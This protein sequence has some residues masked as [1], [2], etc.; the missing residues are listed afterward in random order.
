[1]NHKPI[2]QQLELSIKQQ[3]FIKDSKINNTVNMV[4]ANDRIAMQ[5]VNAHN[6]SEFNP[7]VINQVCNRNEFKHNFTQQ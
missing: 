4:L 7:T 2:E 3:S 5:F 6:E 1:M